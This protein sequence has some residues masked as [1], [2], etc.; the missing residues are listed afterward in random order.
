MAKAPDISSHSHDLFRGKLRPTHG[1]HRAAVL[2]RVWHTFRNRLH[3]SGEA[4]VAPKPFLAG[5]VGAQRRARPIRAVASGTGRTTHLTVLDAITQGDHL[6]RH[7][8]R[9][10]NACVGMSALGRLGWGCDNIARWSRRTRTWRD[11]PGAACS[12][13][14]VDNLVNPSAH[15]VGDVERTIGSDCEPGGTMSCPLWSHYRSRKPIREN[16]AIAGGMIVGQRKDYVVTAL[17]IRRPIPGTMKGDEYTAAIAGWKLLLIVMNHRVRGPMGGKHR[18]RRK[19][20]RAHADGFAS[21]AS[22]FR[23]KHQFLLERIV[24]TLWPAIV[25]AGFQK[26]YFFGGQRGFLVRLIE[27]RPVRMQ[28][29]CPVLRH[30]KAAGR[31]EGKTFCVTNSSG[32]SLSG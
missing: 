5:Q 13:P 6:R 9:Q 26:H 10:R 7:T 11:R 29:I 32:E 20:I 4:A 15:I 31:V 16:F 12:A 25:A 27:I 3:N 23:R 2:L 28:L 18:G 24:V 1:W 8:L 21:I 19:L 17:G 30:K 14:L 22:I